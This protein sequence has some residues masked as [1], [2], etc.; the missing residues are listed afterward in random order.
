MGSLFHQLAHF[1]L[2]TTFHGWYCRH[3]HEIRKETFLVNRRDLPQIRQFHN[4]CSVWSQLCPAQQQSPYSYPFLL[5]T[6]TRYKTQVCCNTT[7][8][9][10]SLRYLFHILLIRFFSLWAACSACPRPWG[11]SSVRLSAGV[12][13]QWK[14]SNFTHCIKPDLR[15]EE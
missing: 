2:I 4:K 13:L 15:K 12:Q 11:S 3:P 1:I 10:M 7:I 14:W 5:R 9:T 6:I 8:E